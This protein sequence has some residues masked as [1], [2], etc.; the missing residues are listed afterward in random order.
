MTDERL[1]TIEIY[2]WVGEDE[3]GSG[4]IGLKQGLTPAGYIPLA[5]VR[6]DKMSQDYLVK[7]ME[8]QAR[9]YGKKISLVRFSFVEVIHEVS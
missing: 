5:G 4:E 8:K 2:A 7:A 9:R 1:K 3:A 6:L